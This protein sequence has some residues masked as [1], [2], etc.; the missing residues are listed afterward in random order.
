MKLNV[1]WEKRKR[2]RKRK[3]NNET[4]FLN[5]LNETYELLC[6]R[7]WHYLKTIIIFATLYIHFPSRKMC[8]HKN[9]M[10]I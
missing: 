10:K 5:S 4:Y 3:G 2:K 8:L 9:R 6:C 1:K 7:V